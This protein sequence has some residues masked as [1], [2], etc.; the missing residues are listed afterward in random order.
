MFPARLVPG[1]RFALLAMLIAVLGNWQN[2]A[3]HAQEFPDFGSFDGANFGKLQAG[4]SV[5]SQFTPAQAD[6]PAMLF[7]TLTI[8]EGYHVYAVDQGVLPGGGGGPLATKILVES[9]AVRVRGPWRP[10]EPPEVHA[11]QEIWVGLELREHAGQV[12]WFAPLEV[13]PG[14]DP[15][16]L[17]ISGQVVGQACDP[18]TCIPFEETFTARQGTGVALPQNLQSAAAT[19]S[20]SEMSLLRVVGYALLGGLILN[21]MPCVLPVIGLKV[22]SFAKQGGQ[23][24][25]Q[26]FLLNL[27]YVAGMLLVFML[28][29]TLAWLVQMGFGGQL[30]ID[31]ENLAWGELN[32]VTWFK[33]AMAALVFAMA[34]SFLGTW[35]IPI[36]GF[37]GSSKATALSSREGPFGA[38]MMG[39]FTTILATP[40]SGPF[41]GPVFGYLISQPVQITYAV[42][43]SIGLG[44]ALPY[45]AVGLAPSLVSWLPKP[46]AWMETFKQLLGFVL[47]ATVVWLLSAIDPDYFIATLTLL[48][49]IWFAC[50]WIGRTPVTATSSAKQTA[51][52]GGVVVATLVGIGAFQ[53]LT[54]GDSVLPWRPYSRAALAE[55]QAQG[56]TVL[57]DFSAQWCLTCKTNLKVAINRAEV[58]QHVEQ[59][60]VVTLLADWTDHNPEIKQALLEHK[61]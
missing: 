7:V 21:L 48:F 27:S 34:L 38:F 37:A 61:S 46:G 54:P 59:N 30:G 58:K 9:D 23:S 18:Q 44:M 42:F 8:S 52:I 40:C 43:A 13:N 3:A 32:T 26:I 36:P 60:G 10:V 24:R 17:T 16:S 41:L 15:S 45:L 57:V 49:G 2:T 29:A 25:A 14:T 28:L 5:E 50:W 1:Y 35:E 53:I 11:D 20:D 12:T 6:R 22:L 4:V 19:Q 39:V 47:L 33:V 51:W 55:A 31:G 56:K